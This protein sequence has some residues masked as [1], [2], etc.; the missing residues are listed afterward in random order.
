MA[1]AGLQP[2][3]ALS[4]KPED[5]DLGIREILV[6]RAVYRAR[7]APKEPG[8]KAAFVMRVARE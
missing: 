5:V 2:G 4:L 8:D 7:L 3:E 1:K 6:E